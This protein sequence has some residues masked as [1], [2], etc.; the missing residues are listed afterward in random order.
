MPVGSLVGI[1]KS[2]S[3]SRPA[4]RTPGVFTEAFLIPKGAVP[5]GINLCCFMNGD[6]V[7]PLGQYGQSPMTAIEVSQTRGLQSIVCYL[8]LNTYWLYPVIAM[9]LP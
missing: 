7:C 8:V 5:E 1:L 3:I 4:P 9:Y 6:F 2:R